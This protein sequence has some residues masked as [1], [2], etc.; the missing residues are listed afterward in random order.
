MSCFYFYLHEF[1]L[2]AVW[3]LSSGNRK[4]IMWSSVNFYVILLPEPENMIDFASI[5]IYVMFFSLG[6]TWSDLLTSLFFN[7]LIEFIILKNILTDLVI[8]G[9]WSLGHIY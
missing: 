7:I 3:A 8:E 1:N 5:I 9:F 4:K 6:L 2:R